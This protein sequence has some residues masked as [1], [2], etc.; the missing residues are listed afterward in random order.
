MLEFALV[1]PVLL[2]LIFGIIEFARAFQA[3]LTISN[4]ARFGVRY[5]VTG[6]YDYAQYC[7]PA[8]IPNIPADLNNSGKA[9][10]DE[11]GTNWP[12]VSYP[13]GPTDRDIREQRNTEEDLARGNT[14]LDVTR[15]VSIGLLR[16]EGVPAGDPGHFNIT[17]CSS[18]SIYHPP[19]EDFCELADGSRGIDPGNPEDP[20]GRRMLVAVTYEH[21]LILPLISQI[22]PSLTL[23]AER[24]GI[25]ENFR[26][27]RVLALPP[28]INVPT[29]TPGPSPTPGPTPTPD[30]SRLVV[31]QPTFV[32]LPDWGFVEIA[33][34]NNDAID[35]AV[36][37]ITIDWNYAE[38]YASALHNN[39][40]GVDFM[41]WDSQTLD[42]YG[43]GSDWACLEP[44]LASTIIFDQ[45]GGGADWD[46]PT[47]ASGFSPNLFAANNTYFIRANYD[48]AG[49]PPFIPWPDWPN[50]LIPDDFGLQISFTNGCV[51]TRDAAG[52]IPPTTTPT[53]TL[54]PTITPLPD[55]SGTDVLGPMLAPADGWH[56]SDIGTTYRGLTSERPASQPDA[57]PQREVF[58]CGSGR[59]IWSTSDGFRFVSRT[60]DSGI[61]EF[62]ARLIGFEAA[63]GDGGWSKVGV[64]VRS[65]ENASAAFSHMLA[66]S[67]NGLNYQYRATNSG[68][69]NGPGQLNTYSLPV[70]LK[71]VKIGKLVIGYY[72]QDGQNW[73]YGSSQLI[74]DVGTNFYFGLAVTAHNNGQFAKAVFDNVSWTV[75]SLETCEYQEDGFGALILE[76]EH[77]MER[78]AS[79]APA[80]YQWL[81]VTDPT[82][83]SGDG[84]M[85]AWPNASN[86]NWQNN[87]T[88]GRMDYDINFDTT[89]TYYVYIRGRADGVG[90]ASNNDSLHVGLDGTV[91]TTGA[92]SQGLNGYVA[93]QWRWR[94]TIGGIN[95]VVS[96]NVTS[97]GPHIL[98]LWMR[99]NGMIADRIFMINSNA[100]GLSRPTTTDVAGY[101]DLIVYENPGWNPNC[102]SY[103]INTP[104]P[105]P[106]RTTTPTRTSTPFCPPGVCTAT[107]TP[108]PTKTPTP[109][110]TKTNTPTSTNTPRFTNTPTRTATPTF[111]AT[112]PLP[113]PAT[114]TRTSAPQPT[115]T[116]TPTPTPKFGG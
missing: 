80:G 34:S 101:W 60:D 32:G 104:T 4:A 66:S 93:N 42:N 7:D 111:T 13:P 30:C 5:G 63:P 113:P 47:T 26:V 52:R 96:L 62:K 114:A 16:T 100:L 83:Y 12:G 48:R 14:I 75:P 86:Y 95:V 109:V 99:E 35:W 92:T 45:V 41:Q 77:F 6:D 94:D 51:Y 53:P 71:V 39:D 24:T 20:A 70:W 36:Q 38:L 76:A 46:S 31:G 55:C 43:C 57:D 19:P 102:S 78:A 11:D 17:V 58:I 29:V 2:F 97:A 108:I 3:W 27:A 56:S 25:L 79:S 18:R 103:V 72:S 8:L 110:P 21:P 87:L 90:G 37:D 22:M 84:A 65:S 10:R 69:A 28:Q 68:N 74:S 50:G 40:I 54:T 23:H 64:M 1:L 73:T 44:Q 59:D 116:F 15:G 85:F 88:G 61:G 106:T 82:G 112:A 89:G 105:T 81:G 9:C 49:G 98:N 33:L 91:V 67:Q 115:S 107:P